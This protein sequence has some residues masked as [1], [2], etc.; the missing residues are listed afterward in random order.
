[1]ADLSN[2]GE[3][4]DAAKALLTRV[5]Q[6]ERELAEIRR[7]ERVQDVLQNEGSAAGRVVAGFF[8]Q[9]LVMLFVADLVE[10]RFLKINQKVCDVLGCTEREILESSFLDRV[11]PDD[12]RKTMH[13]M[14]R[15]V[16]GEPTVDFRN[17]HR[18]ADG[19]YRVFNWTATVDAGRELCYAMAVEIVDP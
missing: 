3:T 12:H 6:L 18:D 17:R 14:E 19:N 15:L 8:A 5:E 4:D 1:M 7:G 11:H 2:S 10:G 9:S 13:E 16:A